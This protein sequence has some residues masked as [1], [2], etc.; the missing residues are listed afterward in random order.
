[1]GILAV[2]LCNYNI[3]YQKL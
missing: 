2:A 1:M 3:A